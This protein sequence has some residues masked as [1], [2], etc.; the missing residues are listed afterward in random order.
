MQRKRFFFSYHV[1]KAGSHENAT[2]SP[3]SQTMHR[4][5]SHVLKKSCYNTVTWIV[6]DAVIQARCS[7]WC[8]LFFPSYTETMSA[9]WGM[10]NRKA[11]VMLCCLGNVAV[12]CQ[13]C[14]FHSFHHLLYSLG[15]LLSWV[16]IKKERKNPKLHITHK[17]GSNSL[18]NFDLFYG[19]ATSR[20][21]FFSLSVLR[22]LIR[23]VADTS[24]NPSFTKRIWLYIFQE[25]KS[26][27]GCW[28]SEGKVKRNSGFC[29][30]LTTVHFVYILA[31]VQI[32]LPMSWANILIIK[33]ERN[34]PSTL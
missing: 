9:R 21:S 17:Y 16:T 15:Y 19:S 33:P 22:V 1:A 6:I 25:I 12:D 3:L 11:T 8:S 18:T 24:S 5:S 14:N 2:P 26:P 13:G 32:R 27:P 10:N 28:V 30:F 34:A 4:Q 29:L 7:S 31:G 23:D 20:C